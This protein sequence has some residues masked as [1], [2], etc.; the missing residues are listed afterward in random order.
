MIQPCIRCGKRW[1]GPTKNTTVCPD[2]L[3]ERQMHLAYMEALYPSAE[4]LGLIGNQDKINEVNS[5]RTVRLHSSGRRV[6]RK[7]EPMGG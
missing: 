2:C 7:S 1:D 3:L 4:Q 6:I 5:L